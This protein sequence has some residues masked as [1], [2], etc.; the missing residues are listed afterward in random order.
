MTRILLAA[1][2][3]CALPSLAL[4]QA[5]TSLASLRVGYNTRKATVK[6]DGELKTQIDAVDR[7]L[8]EATRLGRTGDVRR[9]LAKGTTLLAGR[10]WTPESEFLASVVVRSE[11]VVFDSSRPHTV[12]LEQ[13]FAPALAFES[14]LTAH[15]LLRERPAA[16]PGG[17]PQP[18]VVI[19]DLGT[20]DGVARDL[21]D[22]PFAAELDVQTVPDGTYQLTAELAEGGRALGSVGL[23][24]SIR[25]GLDALVAQLEAAAAQAPEDVRADILYPIDRMRNVNRGNLE[26]RT[27]NPER[28]FAEASAVAA[29]T[30]AGA[31][32]FRGKTG[33]FKRHYRLD[34][35]N[36]ILPYRMYVPSKYDGSRAYPLIIA[37]HG[38]GGTEDSFFDNYDRAFPPLAER[39]G[40]IIAA[41]LGYR[42][43]GS[44][45]W[46]LGTPPADPATRR[47]QERSELDVMEVVKLV[48]RQYR[49][50]DNRIYL[51]GHS[52]GAIGT[53]RL[54]PK[55][56]DLWAAI[57]TFSGSGQ[58]ATL[59]PIK[60]V[61]EFVVHGDADPTVNVQGSRAMVAKARELGIEVT[62]IEVPGG[63]HSSVVAPNFAGLFDFFNTHVKRPL[64]TS[65][66]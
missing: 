64:S 43:D 31:S 49:I 58:P 53:W 23:M 47:V 8:A 9:L 35:A 63:T 20:F 46:G 21:R 26:L 1:V 65:R 61:P 16:A 48:R 14:P 29:A 28:D 5:Q 55:Y 66:Q 11:R 60:H 24:V 25:K 32:P 7:E 17:Q 59:A 13:I 42:V 3:A 30:R 4:A 2:M 40:Y 36:E 50:D 34:A 27:F 44:Y 19:K 22:A 18:G 33:D 38:L 41:P 6:P 52:M 56:P 39:H 37:L 15:L 62:Y 10:A 12:R 51:A 45:G 54:A 57:G